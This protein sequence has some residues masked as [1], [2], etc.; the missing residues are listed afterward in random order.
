MTKSKEISSLLLVCHFYRLY[1]RAQKKDKVTCLVF[2]FS[3]CHNYLLLNCGAL[4][5]TPLFSFAA[6]FYAS[7]KIFG[8]VLPLPEK[9]LQSKSFSGVI[10]TRLVAHKKRTSK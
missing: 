9:S 3:L 2:S 1:R 6:L 8:G 7:A 4:V 10:F 5:R